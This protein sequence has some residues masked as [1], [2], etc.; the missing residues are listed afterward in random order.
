MLRSWPKLRNKLMVEAHQ[1][2]VQ[3]SD[4]VIRLDEFPSRLAHL[5]PDLRILEEVMQGVGGGPRIPFR[6]EQCGFAFKDTFRKS[7]V[8]RGHDWQSGRLCLLQD[9]SLAFLV[10][11]NGD[12]QVQEN[13][14]AVAQALN[15]VGSKR[16]MKTDGAFKAQLARTLF[17]FGARWSIA[18]NV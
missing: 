6:H 1:L 5:R 15:I 2:V 14:G 9:E 7:T 3:V 17:Q 10:A 4:I 13:V 8:A 18:N 16:A 11:I 12:T